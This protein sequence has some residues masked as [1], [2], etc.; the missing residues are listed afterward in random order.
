MTITGEN[1]PNWKGG[2]SKNKKEYQKKWFQENK[3][4]NRKKSRE[5]YQKH[6]ERGREINIKSNKKIKLMVLQHYG[7]T[8]PQCVC[9]EER[10]QEFLTIDHINNDGAEHRRKIKKGGGVA[11]YYWLKL[12][13]LPKGYQVLCFNC[14]IAKSVYEKCPHQHI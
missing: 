14:N 2:I 4:K 7:G 12:N 6:R 11:F 1:N 13:G 8:T 5:W 9:C 10:G 3:E